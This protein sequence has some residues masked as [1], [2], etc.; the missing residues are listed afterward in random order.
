M[1][2]NIICLPHPLR[3]DR[4]HDIA[5][6]LQVA[7]I[8]PQHQAGSDSLLTATTFFKMREVYFNDN[9]DDA[10]YLYVMHVILFRPQKKSHLNRVVHSGY[11]YG[12]GTGTTTPSTSNVSLNQTA[13]I[14]NATV[15]TTVMH[16]AITES[17]GSGNGNGN[18]SDSSDGD[19]ND[20]KN[21]GNDGGSNDNGSSNGNSASTNSD[22][23]SSRVVA[24]IEESTMAA[25]HMVL[26]MQSSNAVVITN[27]MSSILN[28]KS[29]IIGGQAVNTINTNGTPGTN[30]TALSIN[31]A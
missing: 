15:N 24:A 19:G 25:S 23:D 26:P 16:N 11:L 27:P 18:G 13:G 2:C 29:S 6:V 22:S 1:K 10:K 4:A 20:G 28:G 12:L 9:I 7:R 31:T 14:G 30:G 5:S 17:S 3:V 8:G 21:N